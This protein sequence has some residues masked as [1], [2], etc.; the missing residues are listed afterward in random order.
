MMKRNEKCLCFGDQRMNMSK[1][2]LIE[3]NLC[4]HLICFACLV[5]L[6]FEILFDW[7]LS[8]TSLWRLISLAHQ[9]TKLPFLLAQEQN[10]ISFPGQL[11]L[12][13]SCPAQF[14]L[15]TDIS[16]LVCHANNSVDV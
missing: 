13:F 11:D 4:F 7:K 5:V 16:Y 10:L 2:C 12:F 14:K 9:T 1:V 3:I 8:L 15:L 6:S